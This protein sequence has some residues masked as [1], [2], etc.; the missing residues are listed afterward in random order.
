MNIDDLL[1]EIEQRYRDRHEHRCSD[2]SE[3]S[4]RCHMLDGIKVYIENNEGPI[5]VVVFMVCCMFMPMVFLL[6]IMF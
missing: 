3:R 5:S 1:N 6:L 4:N 2:V